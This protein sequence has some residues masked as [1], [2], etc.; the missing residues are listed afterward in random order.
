MIS[1]G[2]CK[3]SELSL[4][5]SVISWPVP[6][7]RILPLLLV[8]YPEG[9][10]SFELLFTMES[11]LNNWTS[12]FYSADFSLW[13]FTSSVF[14]L[15]HSFPFTSLCCCLHSVLRVNRWVDLSAPSEAQALQI[16]P[17]AR[18]S[19][20]CVCWCNQAEV[21]FYWHSIL[22]S[23]LSCPCIFKTP[24]SREFTLSLCQGIKLW[25]F[26][27][28]LLEHLNFFWSA[29][30]FSRQKNSK[31]LC[32]STG[33]AGASRSLAGVSCDSSHCY[34]LINSLEHIEITW[35]PGDQL[36]ILL[37]T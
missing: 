31:G 22:F 20:V 1:F 18:W 21:L 9:R 11:V 14:V 13:W 16:S 27:Q 8:S 24:A 3:N 17:L 28:E 5:S 4:L 7:E 12:G 26:R 19:P 35:M 32:F 34:L 25:C 10:A 2:I 29:T 33:E 36:Q 37:H 6:L 15:V 30:P 23:F